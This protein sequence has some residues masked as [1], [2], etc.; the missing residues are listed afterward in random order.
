MNL[1]IIYG[2]ESLLL[3]P[4]INNFDGRIVRIY[5]NRIPIKK[6]NC[7]DF[8]LCDSFEKNFSDFL[9][10]EY[11]NFKKIIFLGVAF[12]TDKKLFWAEK[13]E[14]LNKNIETNIINY[15]KLT[16]LILPYM[17]RIKSGKFIYFSSFRASLSTRG[18]AI[19]SSS[20][21][22]GEMFFRQIGQEYG[23]VGITSNILRMGYFDGRILETLG[24]DAQEKVKKRISLQR[25][26]SAEDILKSINFFIETD[27]ANSGILELN[28]GIDFG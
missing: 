15:I 11:K 5:N 9:D 25:L 20:K 28:G 26:G 22:F 13:K 19:Y 7:I 16:K 17:M 10:R 2:S 6:K 3:K 1:A 21:A 24:K 27:Y 14:D 12:A 23:S 8:Q 18:T 4:F